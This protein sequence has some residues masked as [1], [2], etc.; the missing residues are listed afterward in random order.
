M[1]DSENEGDSERE[2]RVETSEAYCIY[3]VLH[4]IAP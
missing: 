1:H 3:D 2:H 4:L